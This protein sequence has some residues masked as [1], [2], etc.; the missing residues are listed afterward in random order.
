M[1][2]PSALRWR[3]VPADAI[4]WRE[5]N[6]ECV[7]RNERSGST[8][9]LGPLAA[10][11]LKLLL[12]ADSALYVADIAATF[13]DECPNEIGPAAGAQPS[14]FGAAP[15]ANAPDGHAAIDAVLSEFRRLGL[16]ESEAR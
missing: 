10:W 1:L 7:V 5:W 9:L 11:V 2:S 15:T 6:G 8:H 16:A 14:E 13:N 12:Q 4:A 3:S